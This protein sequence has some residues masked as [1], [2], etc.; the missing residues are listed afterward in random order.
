MTFVYFLFIILLNFFLFKKLKSFEKILKISDI[1]NKRKIH[2]KSVPLLG[3]TYFIINL[4]FILI[5]SYSINFNFLNLSLNNTSIYSIILGTLSFYILGYLDDKDNKLS[6]NLRLLISSIIIFL[7][8]LFDKDMLLKSLT[9]SF[10]ISNNIINFPVYI[11]W[12]L[13]IFCFLVLINAFN[14]M[15]GINLLATSFILFI[16]FNFYFLGFFNIYF[17]ILV[18]FFIFFFKYNYNYQIF[19]GSSGI[20]PT[21]FLIGYLFIKGYNQN[22]LIYSDWVFVILLVPLFEL[23]RLMFIRIKKKQNPFLADQNH[24]HHYIY[25][26]FNYNKT[27]I[28]LLI[29]Y[30]LPS[31]I[32]IFKISVYFV[33]LLLAVYFYLI[34]K[35]KTQI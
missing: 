11:S 13:T 17:I 9:I 35:Y 2:K 16:F 15:D 6:P 29:I 26:N 33:F 19:F 8:L 24:L 14:M 34:N 30:F 7:I 27:I 12:F 23:M 3:G 32:V 25:L 22:L 31:L 4:F 28:I 18:P 20:M 10:L 1:P 21:S 5:I